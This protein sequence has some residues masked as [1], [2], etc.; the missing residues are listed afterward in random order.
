[1]NSHYCSSK[2]TRKDTLLRHV[3]K[4]HPARPPTAGNPSPSSLGNQQLPDLAATDISASS[5]LGQPGVEP[6]NEGCTNGQGQILVDEPGEP[7]E[8]H[9]MDHPD[10]WI[11]SADFE[12]GS[13]RGSI[14]QAPG[15]SKTPDQSEN[16]TGGNVDDIN[17][18]GEPAAT[19]RPSDM[20]TRDASYLIDPFLSDGQDLWLPNNAGEYFQLTELDLDMTLRSPFLF[21]ES[22][23]PIHSP[24]AG[25]TSPGARSMPD[26]ATKA[27][28]DGGDGASTFS[29]E[30]GM[31]SMLSPPG[32]VE[33][34]MNK[35]MARVHS[36]AALAGDTN[37][38]VPPSRH[39]A[40]RYLTA[41]VR[42][43]DPHTP[44]I[45]FAT[46]RPASASRWS[47]SYPPRVAE[48]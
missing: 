15:V 40:S 10:T 30:G 42:Y 27:T 41:Y 20:P 12:E 44:L 33:L 16:Q 1:M 25:H 7:R 38:F 23:H 13:R 6:S 26:A 14:Q 39:R 32:N 46:F 21:P 48:C 29:S 24:Q 31:E 36:F 19:G 3:R 22:Y 18:L 45:H 37:R 47:L 34:D 4:F 43:F 2:F 9:G 5:N 17:L 28:L 35:F 11:S 8:P